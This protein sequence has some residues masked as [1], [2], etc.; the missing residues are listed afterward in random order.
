[1]RQAVVLD[2]VLPDSD[3]LPSDPNLVEFKQELLRERQEFVVTALYSA[4]PR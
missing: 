3:T 4:F 1:M 2:K